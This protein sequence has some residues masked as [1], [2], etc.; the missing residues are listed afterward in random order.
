MNMYCRDTCF[1]TLLKV[2]DHLLLRFQSLHVFKRLAVKGQQGGEKEVK[3]QG[4]LNHLGNF[5]RGGRYEVYAGGPPRAL[6][7]LQQ[8]AMELR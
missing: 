5:G 7:L 3:A 6:E 1:K 2:Y 4:S 8:A